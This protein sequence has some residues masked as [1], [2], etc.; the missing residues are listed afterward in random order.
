MHLLTEVQTARNSTTNY[1][2][3]RIQTGQD[4]AVR[5]VCYSPQKRMNLKQAFLNK[6]PVKITGVK[7]TASKRFHKQEQ[8]FTIAKH[9]KV[10]PTSL[11]YTFNEHF[12]N[13]LC[14]ITEALEKDVYETL[15]VKAKVLKNRKISK[16]L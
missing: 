14:T 8:E 9:A 13:Q 15:D 3:C 5:T 4:K 12:S 6:S 16:L 1:F 2:N 11:P 10:T 7:Q